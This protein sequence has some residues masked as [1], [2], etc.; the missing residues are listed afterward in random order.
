MSYCS[1]GGMLTCIWEAQVIHCQNKDFKYFCFILKRDVCLFFVLITITQW[2]LR[3]C[4]GCLSIGR[5]L[6]LMPLHQPPSPHTLYNI[7]HMCS[8]APETKHTFIDLCRLRTQI[9][10]ANEAEDCEYMFISNARVWK[11]KHT[12]RIKYIIVIK[13]L[14][15]FLSIHYIQASSNK[16]LDISN[17]CQINWVNSNRRK[18]FYDSVPPYLIAPMYSPWCPNPFLPPLF[19]SVPP[20]IQSAASCDTQ[21]KA[22]AHFLLPA[23][24]NRAECSRHLRMQ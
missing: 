11:Y 16:V 17:K 3:L 18:H 24:P 4:S 20:V 19:P 23:Q 15:L 5:P 14:M 7:S 22:T 21:L 12:C 8:K 1:N 10:P 9:I 6:E 2:V 13:L